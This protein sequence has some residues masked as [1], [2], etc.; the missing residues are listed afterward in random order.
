[1]QSLALLLDHDG[2]KCG[3]CQDLLGWT[4]EM[5]MLRL[6]Y[7]ETTPEPE[8]NAKEIFYLSIFNHL[9]LPT[10]QNRKSDASCCSSDQLRGYLIELN[11]LLLMQFRP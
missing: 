7:W 10:V 4:I 1:M 9:L 11:A 8:S 5:E 2:L 3:G 6:S